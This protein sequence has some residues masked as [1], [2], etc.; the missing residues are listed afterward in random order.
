MVAAYAKEIDLVKPGMDLTPSSALQ[1]HDDR[2]RD[3]Q[4][5]TQKQVLQ[6]LLL[7]PAHLYALQVPA[8]APSGSIDF[9]MRSSRARRY[10]LSDEASERVADQHMLVT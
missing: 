1:L 9:K 4:A 3:K 6:V 2:N 5:I 7:H 10:V 8:E